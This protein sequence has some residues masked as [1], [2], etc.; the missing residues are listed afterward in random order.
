MIQINDYIFFLE[1]FFNDSI[2]IVDDFKD[3][4]RFIEI[5]CFP[6]KPYLLVMEVSNRSIRIDKISKVPQ[7]DFSLYNFNFDNI[8]EAKKLCYELKVRGGFE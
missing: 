4:L 1:E 3:D 2:V 7:I 8:E 5:D 6:N